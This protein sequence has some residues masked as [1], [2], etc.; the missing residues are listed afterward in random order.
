MRPALVRAV[1]IIAMVAAFVIDLLTP[2]LFVT[3]IL[4]DAPIVLSSLTRSSRFTALLVVAALAANIVAGYANGVTE[5]HH[6]DPL[7]IGDRILAGLSIVFVGYLST[8]V[9]QTAQRAGKLEA[10][11]ARAQ[12]EA[13]LAAAIE[14]VRT[15]LSLDLVQRAVARETTTLFDCDRARF[16]LTDGSNAVTLVARRDVADVDDEAGRPAPETASLVQHALD[17]S[18]ILPIVRS[19]AFGRL[20]LDHLGAPSALALPIADRDH[21]FGV[22]IALGRSEGSFTDAAGFAHAFA[23][24]AANALAQARLFAQLDER[25]AALEE[26]SAII[27]DL[28]YA[29][30][31]DLRTPLAA[32]GMTMRQA[33]AGAYGALP[34]AYDEILARS[35][36]ATDDVT[37]LAETLL[38]VARFESGDRLPRR[39]RVDLAAIARQIAGELAA[40][41]GAHDVTLRVEGPP[42]VPV[43]GDRD[44]LRR[45]VTNLVANAVQHSPAGGEV[46]IALASHAA[47]VRLSV[48]DDGYGV[49]D[50]ARPYLFMRFVRGSDRRGAGSG[51]GLY[52]ARRVAQESG[53]RIDYAPRSP[54]GSVFTL[55]L[56]AVEQL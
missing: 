39:E 56:P 37:R 14:R 7:G 10:Q 51:L 41:A 28:V 40:L 33:R 4:L 24:Q 23:Q 12:R 31:H 38:L 21:R 34:P 36:T 49:P 54:Q 11:Q 2:Q 19:D 13:Q 25:N 9:Q 20:V 5:H 55:T 26:R 15:S 1:C 3:A 29:L 8:A 47:G 16:V 18:T 50:A 30:S 53:G 42:S 46:A 6:W 32:L 27:R 35:I 43:M 17:S 52:I 48:T 45:A 22:V 44:D